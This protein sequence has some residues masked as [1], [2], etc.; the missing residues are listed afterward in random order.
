MTQ[1]KKIKIKPSPYK[2]DLFSHGTTKGKRKKEKK[3][4]TQHESEITGLCIMRLIQKSSEGEFTYFD[5]TQ[6]N[7]SALLLMIQL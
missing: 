3:E 2:Y 6:T 7:F 5:N 4:G 1:Q